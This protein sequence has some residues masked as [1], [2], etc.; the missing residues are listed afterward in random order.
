[1]EEKDAEM[2]SPARLFQQKMVDQIMDVKAM[3][4]EFDFTSMGSI[5]EKKQVLIRKNELVE[6]RLAEVEMK[7]QS[8]AKML[9]QL[10]LKHYEDTKQ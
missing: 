9:N 8:H 2:A 6:Q 7:G 3:S 1:M 5:Y 10:Q 4:K